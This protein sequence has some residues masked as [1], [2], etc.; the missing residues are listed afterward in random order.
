MADMMADV[1]ADVI[2]KHQVVRLQELSA[3]LRPLAGGKASTLA[4]LLQAGY[5]VPDGFVILPAAFVDEQ[6]APAA[7]QQVTT[8]LHALRKQA[9]D[10]P[11]AVRSSALQEDSAQASFA[12]EFESVLNVTDDQALLAAIAKVYHSAQSARVSA[13]RAAH[14]LDAAHQIAVIVQRM[15]PA[16]LA[17]VLF[18][19]D[20]ITGSYGN[21]LGNYVHGL[22]EQLVSGEAN[23]DTFTLRRSGR[24]WPNRRYCADSSESRSR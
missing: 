2:T 24:G 3:A 13:Y 1:I 12:G 20:P 11:V 19:A 10:V 4:K 18:T 21:M 15:V 16:D 23:A 17:G 8:H 14:G 6:L 7:W 22:G 9:A 5:P